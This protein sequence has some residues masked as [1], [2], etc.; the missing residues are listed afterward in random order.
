[1][2]RFP[3]LVEQDEDGVFIAHVPSLPGCHTQA[4]SLAE[5]EKRIHVAIR[6]YLEVA[7]K[8]RTPIQPN[9]FIGAHLVDVA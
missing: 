7:R 9:R 5:V 8:R 1:M 4:K 3:V 6:L 2:K